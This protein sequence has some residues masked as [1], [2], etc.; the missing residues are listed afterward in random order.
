[1]KVLLLIATVA[2]AAMTFTA[3]LS[4]APLSPAMSLEQIMGGSFDRHGGGCDTP[5]DIRQHPRCQ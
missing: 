3:P 2:A 5:R 4:A 1:M